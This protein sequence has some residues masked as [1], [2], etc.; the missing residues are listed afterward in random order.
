MK[1]LDCK[2]SE[3][4]KTLKPSTKVLI[5]RHGY[6]KWWKAYGCGQTSKRKNA[7][8]Y[9]IEEI[10]EDDFLKG[11]LTRHCT[12]LKLVV[13]KKKAKKKKTVLKSVTSE[14]EFI[15]FLDYELQSTIWKNMTNPDNFVSPKGVWKAINSKYH[16]VEKIN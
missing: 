14:E 6:G 5:K 4:L 11:R 15:H 16:L 2:N 9:T 13:K 7:H 3:L 8:A 10:L 12:I 1:T